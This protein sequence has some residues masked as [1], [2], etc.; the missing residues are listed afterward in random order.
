V[1]YFAA[2]CE[3]IMN[4]LSHRLRA[5]RIL[6]SAG[7]LCAL[8]IPAFAGD[9][10]PKSAAANSP[11]GNSAQP[12]PV[13]QKKIYTNEDVESLAHKSGVSTVGNAAPDDSAAPDAQGT[14]ERQILSTPRAHTP[15]AP[16]KDP[17]LYAAQ[18]LALTARMDGID[19][20]VQEL[21]S[22]VASDAAPGPSAPGINFGLNIYAPCDGITTDAQIQQLLQQRA[23]LDAQISDL[24]G[25]A[26]LN[27][28]DSGVFRNASAI[29][30]RSTTI[31]TRETLNAL[32]IDLA[33]ARGT[34][35]AMHQEAAAQNAKIIPE[36]KFGGGFT[37][38]FLKRL[39]SQ[40]A[41]AQQQID[42]VED[43]AR[44]EGVAPNTLP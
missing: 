42:A 40:Q 9:G 3:V 4:A 13:R 32:Q 11:D 2:A 29:A 35:A 14:G 31:P 26:Q 12:S 23:Q 41:A 1:Q 24:E 10:T 39:N 5:S 20:R 21:R 27:G 38:N 17:A 43:T 16:D 25:R 18:Y 8:S 34:E 7:L 28:I 33:Q 6:L 36:T 37:A 22:F 44:H 19:N 15:L 30:P